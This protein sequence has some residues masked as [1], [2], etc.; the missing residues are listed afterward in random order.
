VNLAGDGLPCGENLAGLDAS[1]KFMRGWKLSGASLP[2]LAAVLLA[3]CIQPKP[4]PIMGQAPSF[5]LTA[6]TGQP[7][8]SKSLAG[9]IW[10]ADFVYTNCTGPCP[11][12][13]SQ[14]RQ[15]QDRTAEMPDVTL[16]SFT[17]DPARDTP[18]V[19]AAYAKHFRANPERWF[20]LTGE[21]ARLNDVALTGFKLNSV[22]TSLSHSTRFALVDR[23]GRIRGYYISTDDDFMTRLLHDIRQLEREKS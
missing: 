6:E 2:A 11:M 7:F 23:A 16:V 22:D 13:S 3:G 20:F 17:V 19:L 10:V 18:S 4:L 14:M 1:I 12:M 21:P 15:I 5:Q 8:D 9:R